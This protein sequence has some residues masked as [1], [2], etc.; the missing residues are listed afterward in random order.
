MSGK[1]ILHG[2]SGSGLIGTG[3]EYFLD[4]NSIT[5]V[6][7]NE[8]ER[9]SIQHGGSLTAK[10]GGM[11]NSS[12]SIRIED[13]KITEILINHN[14]MT[15]AF[16]LE[17]V[18]VSDISDISDISSNST[19]ELERNKPLY[20]LD[21]G[22]K[23]IIYVY[24]DY[25]VISHRGVLNALA[26]GIKG[27]KTLYF[28]DITSVQFKKPG[29]S[30]GY[31]QFSIPGGNESKGGVFSAMSDENTVAISQNAQI[32]QI[33]EIVEYINKKIREV[34]S[35]S[36]ASTTVVNQISSADELKKFKELLDSGVITQEEFDA[37]KKQ[38]LGL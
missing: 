29:L 33:E 27:D 6:K 5:N 35:N 20:I 11:R 28:S 19:S 15:G 34:K 21:G 13:G 31:I 14:R 22:L 26:M 24:E 9:V 12:N 25:I 16:N 36:G 18:S 2:Y 10:I 32:Y 3:M 7:K 8:T 23:D 4:G 30:A 17:V 38:L 1:L 37:K